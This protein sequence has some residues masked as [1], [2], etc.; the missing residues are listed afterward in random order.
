VLNDVTATKN[1]AIWAVGHIDEQQ[2]IALRWT[3]TGWRYVET[4][5]L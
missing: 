5:P 2:P 1:G 4:A 3:G